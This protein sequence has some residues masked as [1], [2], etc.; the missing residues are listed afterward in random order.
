MMVISSLSCSSCFP[1]LLVDILHVLQ[2]SHGL[3]FLFLCVME[4]QLFILFQR[5]FPAPRSPFPAGAAGTTLCIRSTELIDCHLLLS[6]FNVFRDIVFHHVD[7][8]SPW[9]QRW[10]GR[11]IQ[12]SGLCGGKLSEN[13]SMHCWVILCAHNHT[14]THRGENNTLLPATSACRVIKENY[15][16]SKDEVFDWEVEATTF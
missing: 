13:A 4:P 16:L 14:R 11:R 10:S 7:W 9:G 1:G 12:S 6:R 2:S 8:V 15:R 3:G 5:P